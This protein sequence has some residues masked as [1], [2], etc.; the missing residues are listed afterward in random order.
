MKLLL[1]E[2]G[3]YTAIAVIIMAVMFGP[4]LL[5]LII[6]LSITKRNKKA[7]KVWYIIAGIYLVVSLGICGGMM[8]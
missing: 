8:V 7:A 6:G 4:P 1:F 5:C 3:D 2:G